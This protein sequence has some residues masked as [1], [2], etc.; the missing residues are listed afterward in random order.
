[1]R[2]QPRCLALLWAGALLIFTVAYLLAVRSVV[3]LTVGVKCAWWA[4]LDDVCDVLDII[5][6]IWQARRDR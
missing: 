4:W 2:R 3:A 6:P 5:A 1:M